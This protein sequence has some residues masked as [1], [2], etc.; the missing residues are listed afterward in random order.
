MPGSAFDS[1][2]AARSVH[3]PPNDR[4]RPSPTLES[5]ASVTLLTTKVRVAVWAPAGSGVSARP[6]TIASATP[7]AACTRRP[8]RRVEL[9][10]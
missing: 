9:T 10:S 7:R 4:H 5:L 8:R 1:S 2:I 6:A 3:A